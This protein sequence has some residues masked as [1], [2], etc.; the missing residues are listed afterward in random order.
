MNRK[1]PQATV[2]IPNWNGAGHL[3]ECLDS[4]AAQTFRD[5]ETLLVDNGSTD[6]S[7]SLVER[8]YPWVRVIGLA[9]NLGFSTAVNVGIRESQ[10]E[11]VVLLNNDT[12][13]RRDWLEALIRDMSHWPEA[14]F[15][16]SRMLRYEP[17]HLVDSAGDHF[18]LLSGAG[19]NIGAGD[20]EGLHKQPAWIFGACAGAAIYRRSLFEDIGVFDEDFFLVFED[21]D[22]DLRAQVAG[23]HCLY[24]PDAVVLHKRGGSTDATSLEVAVRS[25]RNHVWV[26]GKNLPPLL[27]TWWFG[28]FVLRMLAHLVTGAI[29]RARALLSGSRSAGQSEPKTGPRDLRNLPTHYLPVLKSALRALPAKRREVAHLRRLGSLKLL[30]R[31][32]RLPSPVTIHRSGR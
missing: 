16:A 2:I 31:L 30:S 6:A 18:S 24:I 9:Q 10:S 19:N 11:Y 25:W 7:V 27:L 26:A 32:R 5:F 12:R 22:L 17:P 15:A 1:I 4:L 3:R 23:H 13:A 21:V 8:D 29:R 20:P 28:V 14:S